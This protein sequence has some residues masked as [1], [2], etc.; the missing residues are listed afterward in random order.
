M[1]DYLTKPIVSEQLME[2]LAYRL[3]PQSA[4]TPPILSIEANVQT[5]N[6]PGGWDET[7]ALLHL[8]GDSELLDE[9]IVLFLTE[10]PKQLRDLTRLQA[11]GN[12]NELANT[13][14]AIKGTIAHFYDATATEAVFQLEQTA[15]NSQS[16]DYL[17][18]TETVVKAVTDLLNNLLLAKNKK[19]FSNEIV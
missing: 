2:V 9:L 10:G 15:R 6:T 11:E 1:D 13:A 14:H 17:G 3:G 5:D 7:A 12:I 19:A 4:E 18:M 16:A 8:E